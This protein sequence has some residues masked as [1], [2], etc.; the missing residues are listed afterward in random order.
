ML[1]ASAD[2]R[3]SVVS[4]CRR[5]LQGM[6]AACLRLAALN[7]DVSVYS[8]GAGGPSHIPGLSF[9][10]V[11]SC[12]AAGLVVLCLFQC[13]QRCQDFD[14]TG[15]RHCCLGAQVRFGMACTGCALLRCCRVLLG[16][17]VAVGLKYAAGCAGRA[18]VV[19]VQG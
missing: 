10:A 2:C 16:V 12:E 17:C 8:S 9:R 11:V 4:V 15:R 3:R 13:V 14:G 6:F 7:R 5:L 18:Q 1:L 19:A